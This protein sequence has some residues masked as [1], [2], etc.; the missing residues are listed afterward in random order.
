VPR[1]PPNVGSVKGV[2][3]KIGDAVIEVATANPRTPVNINKWGAKTP[4]MLGGFSVVV[5]LYVD[6]V[7]RALAQ[8]LAAGARQAGPVQDVPAG[9]RVTVV[10][11]PFGHAWTLVAVNEE[12]SVAEHNR[13]WDAS[14]SP[15]HR[16]QG[17]RMEITN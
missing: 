9:D 17:P 3:L 12:M 1:H 11:D 7:D 10:E 4:E 15:T 8:A 14:V 2:T 16:G 6:D 13:R 5:T